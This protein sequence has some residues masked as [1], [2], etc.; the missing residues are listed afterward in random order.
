MLCLT[1]TLF[2]AKVWCFRGGFGGEGIKESC[3]YTTKSSWFEFARVVVLFSAT[4]VEML[5]W[6]LLRAP[7][8][9]TALPPFE[10]PGAPLIGIIFG[11]MVCWIEG[12][13]RGEEQSVFGYPF[14]T[15]GHRDASFHIYLPTSRLESM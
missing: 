5:A 15:K 10:V 14:G 1:A 2:A 12:F 9:F 6:L 4:K 7:S 13:A 8:H 11:T 3:K